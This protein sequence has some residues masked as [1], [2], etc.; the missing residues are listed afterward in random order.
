MSA[1]HY[2][3]LS[4]RELLWHLRGEETRLKA[5]LTEVQR[6][7]AMLEADRRRQNEV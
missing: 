3:R 6:Q 7:M 4:E 5:E 1:Q 2:A